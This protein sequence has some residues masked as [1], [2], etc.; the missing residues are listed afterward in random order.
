MSEIGGIFNFDGAPV[1]RALLQK[2]G[3]V[4]SKRGPDGGM[5]IISDTVGM[6][7]RAFHTN[8]ESRLERQPLHSSTGQILT[9]DG[10]LDNRE[11]LIGRLNL[12][13]G[14]NRTDVALVMA[15][16]QEWKIDFLVQLVGDFALSFY[17]PATRTLLLARDPF[18]TRPLYYHINDKSIIWSTEIEALFAVGSI[19]LEVDDNYIARYLV[20]E[21]EPGTTPYKGIQGIPPGSVVIVRGPQ[22]EMRRYWMPNVDRKIIY[23]NDADYEEEFRRLLHEAVRVRL[24][25]DAPVWSELSGGLDSSSIVCL[26]DQILEAGDAYTPGLNTISYYSQSSP[27]TRESEFIQCVEEHRGRKTTYVNDDL[28]WLRFPTFEERAFSIPTQLH[29]VA[30]RY[31]H[32]AKEM[33]RSASRVLLTGIGGDHLLWS[34][35]ITSPELADMLRGLKLIRLHRGLKAWSNASQRPYLEMLWR[36]AILFNLPQSLRK[37]QCIRKAPWI[38]QVFINRMNIRDQ[39]FN[40]QNGRGFDR[41]SDIQQWYYLMSVISIV[42]TGFINEQVHADIS[43]PFLHRPLVEFMLAVPFDQKLR[44]G[45]TR[46]VM[47]RAMAGI[48][49]EKIRLRKTKGGADEALFRAL[50]RE[51]STIDEMFVNSRA[52]MRGYVEPHLLREEL[53]KARLGLSS[54]TYVLWKTVALEFW[55]QAIERQSGTYDSSVMSAQA[56]TLVR[57]GL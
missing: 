11:D 46:S 44:P 17:D 6:V 50:A 7:Y 28:Y 42:S 49:P 53:E 10:R 55:L 47:R 40:R 36:G 29:C 26:A 1:E 33:N 52:C 12:N 45:E 4:L 37:R 51:W 41:P 13:G 34:E 43:H 32:L 8:K 21:Q 25:A 16:W 57:A 20:T 22:T 18:G 2:M 15:A 48:L 56:T 3:T 9:W 31:S 30:G 19:P 23:K 38:N 27:T 14:S 35:V 24:R 5:E 54:Q 39:L